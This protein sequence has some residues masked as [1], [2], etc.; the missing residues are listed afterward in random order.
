MTGLTKDQLIE[1]RSRI[2]GSDI[3]KLT[4]GMWF[5]L[6]LEK[7]AREE[8]EDLT[9]V[10]PVQIGI[11]TEPLNLAWFEHTTGHQVFGR[12]EVYRHPTHA[13]IGTT[14]DGL[15]LIEGAPAIVQAKHTNAF[16]KIE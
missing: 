7:T 12:G 2:G 13:Y 3:S 8:P 11:I 4:S 5:E 6:W 14:I 16:A 9:W 10:L 1:R 15:V